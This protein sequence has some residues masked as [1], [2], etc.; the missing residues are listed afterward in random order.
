MS[1]MQWNLEGLGEV[2]GQLDTAERQINTGV[3]GVLRE[4]GKVLQKAIEKNT[5][6]GDA[7]HG[8]HAKDDVQISSVRTQAQT[9]YKHLLVGYGPSSYWYMWFLEEGTYSKGNPKGI[10]PRKH[11]YQAFN[12]VQSQVQGVMARELAEVVRGVG[13]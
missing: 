7:Q 2:I 9:S 13:E 3:N 4:G 12:S 1:G 5:P 6:K 8:K 10:A 11:T